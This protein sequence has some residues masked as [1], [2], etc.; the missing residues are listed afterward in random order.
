MEVPNQQ[1]EVWPFSLAAFVFFFI[2]F[3]FFFCFPIG[4][5]RFTLNMFFCFFPFHPQFFLGGGG[6]KIHGI[7]QGHH[8][9]LA[10]GLSQ[11]ISLQ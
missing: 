11:S 4:V 7:L 10:V 9:A 2:I 5:R 1:A 8:R 6:L 3:A